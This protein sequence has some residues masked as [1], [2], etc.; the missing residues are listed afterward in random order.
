MSI[1]IPRILIV[2]GIPGAGKDTLVARSLAELPVEVHIPLVDVDEMVARVQSH[3]QRRDLAFE[4]AMDGF[5]RRR[6]FTRLDEFLHADQEWTVRTVQEQARRYGLRYVI[7]P[8][9]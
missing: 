1:T 7:I 5:I 4:M 8:A 9:L 2:E 6:G 3:V